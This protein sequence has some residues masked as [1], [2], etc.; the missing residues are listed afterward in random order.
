MEFEAAVL[1][2]HMGDEPILEDVRTEGLLDNLTLS[3]RAQQTYRNSGTTN[4]EATYTFPLPLDAVLLGFHVQIGD[5]KLAGRIVEKSAGEEAYEDAITDGDTAILLEQ[6]RPGMYSASVGNLLPNETAKL[7]IEYSL[8]LRWNENKVRIHIPTTLAPFY[9]DPNAAGLEPHQTPEYSATDERGFHLNINVVG[10]LQHAKFHSPS[11]SINATESDTGTQIQFQ[12]GAAMDRDFILE[13]TSANEQVSG[14][15][16]A[17]D[18]DGWVALASFRPDLGEI[19]TDC[20]PRSSKIVVDCSGS[21][22][23]DSITQA[24]KALERILDGLR[25]GDYFDIISFGSDHKLLFGKETAVSD[26]SVARARAFVRKLDADMGGTEVAEALQAAYGDNGTLAFKIN[27]EM[28]RDILLIT[29]GEVW[30]TEQI[31]TDAQNSGYRIFSVGVGSAVQESFLRRLAQKTGGACELVSPNENMAGRI[32]RHFQRIYTQ[33]IAHAEVIWPGKTNFILPKKIEAVFSGDTIHTYAWFAKKPKGVVTL[34]VK[35]ADGRIIPHPAKL[36]DCATINTPDG[37][38]DQP[39]ATTLARMAA[40]SRLEILQDENEATNLAV[41]YQLVSENTNCIVIDIHADGEKAEGLPEL[42]KVRQIAAAG[43]GGMGSANIVYDSPLPKMRMSVQSGYS[44]KQESVLC[45]DEPRPEMA[46]TRYLLVAALN[47]SRATTPKS[48]EELWS[49]GLGSDILDALA[50][51]VS[52]GFDEQ[53]VVAAFL[54]LVSA[55]SDGDGLLRNARRAV[56]KFFKSANPDV[57]VLEA[58]ETILANSRMY[59]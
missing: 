26:A 4:I 3:I 32:H 36:K 50:A 34:N 51:L 33:A 57:A 22:T 12:P 14:C 19:S 47:N 10:V 41:R 15:L 55:S 17:Q 7:T 16:L 25:E 58:V 42:Y 1:E 23:G 27:P 6:I 39:A 11:H 54:H 9:G 37:M 28:R 20:I 13:A 45:C 29:D 44:R 21:M 24:R 52:N 49:W 43:W 18:L 48:L 31:I 40:A 5:R 38:N 35:L 56:K 53:S 59:L 8:M 2:S 46:D 30:E